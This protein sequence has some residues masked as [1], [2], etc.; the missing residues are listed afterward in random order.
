MGHWDMNEELKIAI[1]NFSGKFIRLHLGCGGRHFN[2]YINI[3]FPQDNQPLVETGADVF[4][5]ITTL[6]LPMDS[7]DEILLHHVFEHFS[8]PVALALL[9]NWNLWLKKGGLLEIST[10]DA[11]ECAR[12]I[13]SNIPYAE[14]MK[15]VRHL[16]G[17]HEEDKWSYH[18]DYWFK[19]RFVC[20]LERLNYK[21]IDVQKIHEDYGVF[22]I[23]V[24][25]VK[26]QNV[27][28]ENLL[29]AADELLLQS[30]L[31]VVE[32]PMFE[33]WKSKLLRSVNYYGAG[34]KC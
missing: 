3:D 23:N 29:A 10:P 19:E 15:L 8:R 6:A 33:I 9:I 32:T 21:I 27:D 30:T 22:N 13:A 28:L 31:G 11:E 12:G 34:G 2:D 7:V 26:A 4:A 24:K 5:D 14:K 16:A 20:T 18:L 17:S 25:A 1:K